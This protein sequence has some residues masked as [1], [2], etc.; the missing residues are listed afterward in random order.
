VEEKK[1][2]QV[3]K[4]KRKVRRKNSRSREWATRTA[5]GAASRRK[6]NRGKAKER[7]KQQKKEREE[8][9]KGEQSKAKRKRKEETSRKRLESGNQDGLPSKSE[10]TSRLSEKSSTKIPEYRRESLPEVVYAKAHERA[11]ER[12]KGARRKKGIR[13]MSRFSARKARA[14]S[15]TYGEPWPKY[16]VNYVKP[17]G[18]GAQEARTKAQGK[19]DK[20]MTKRQRK[21][22]SKAERCRQRAKSKRLEKKNVSLEEAEVRTPQANPTTRSKRNGGLRTLGKMLW[23]M[24]KPFKAG[25]KQQTTGSKQEAGDGAP[26]GSGIG[27][28]S[29]P[30]QAPEDGAPG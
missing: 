7:R 11:H 8:H 12:G 10:P 18:I 15:E 14:I 27:I 16:I 3:A 19:D 28:G 17:F 24:P 6:A 22:R 25:K 9:E 4:I 20:E 26:G 2:P 30:G 21:R 23:R 29:A 1:D 13:P 5:T